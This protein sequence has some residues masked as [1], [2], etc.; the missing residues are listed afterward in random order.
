MS[1]NIFLTIINIFCLKLC[2]IFTF[3]F[4]NEWLSCRTSKTLNSLWNW[5]LLI[6]LLSTLNLL[7]LVRSLSNMNRLLRSFNWQIFF[8]LRIYFRILVGFNVISIIFLQRLSYSI[9]IWKRL[10]RVVGNSRDL[11]VSIDY[12]I[13][14]HKFGYINILNFYSFIITWVYVIIKSFVYDL[15]LLLIIRSI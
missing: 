2:L 9:C 10:F 4:F 3:S 5:G 12:F 8:K 1:K 7:I 15:I 14:N 13:W 11:I 6:I